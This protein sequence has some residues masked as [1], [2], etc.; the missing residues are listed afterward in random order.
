M[1][2]QPTYE[3]LIETI[4]ESVFDEAAWSGVTESLERLLDIQGHHVALLDP[5]REDPR[6]VFSRLYKDG[7]P[8]PDLE[9]EY[10]RDYA[11]LDE[12]VSRMD[13]LPFGEP[14]DNRQS[15]TRDEMR[16]TSAMYNDFLRRVGGTNQVCVRLDGT[17]SGADFWTLTRIRP[18]PFETAALDQ[19]GGL[20]RHMGRMVQMRRTLAKVDALGLALTEVL[21]HAGAAFFLLDRKGKIVEC[22]A[23]A[24]GLLAAD[25]GLE[26]Q[27]GTL[28][29]CSPSA[30][31]AFRTALREALSEAVPEASSV[32]I[33]TGRHGQWLWAHVSPVPQR[34]EMVS[35]RV[36][37]LVV[38][39]DPWAER[40]VDP[41]IVRKILGV[42]A[43]EAEVAALVAE[44]RTVAEIAAL[45]HR[46]VASVR[47]HLRELYGKTGLRGQT[48]LL[49]VVQAAFGT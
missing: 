27:D 48:D 21:A 43:A 15:F 7:A 3:R 46:S 35:D 33:P 45:R 42:T 32:R 29:A 18:K 9:A 25:G 37:A 49:R 31:R 34:L 30:E 23:R 38:V 40:K 5:E 44:G 11:A 36:A 2:S 6:F 1:S 14:V 39:R 12:R 24:S 13:Q 10:V 8:A 22:N 16:R 4:Y 26:A 20:A 41:V 28:A 19:L 17:T 47:W